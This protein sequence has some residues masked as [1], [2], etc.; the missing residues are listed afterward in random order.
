M[1]RPHHTGSVTPADLHRPAAGL[2]RFVEQVSVTRAT[3]APTPIER[4]PDG[5]AS[6]V[7]RARGSARCELFVVGPRTR[8]LFKRPAPADLAISIRFRPGQVGR[9]LGVPAGELTDLVLFVDQLWGDQGT[10]L[11]DALSAAAPPARLE[12]LQ[13]ALVARAGQS[14]EPPAAT[15]AR[16]AVGLLI[17]CGGAARIGA[18][19]AQLGITPRHLRRVFVA[20]VGVGPKE[21]ARM[22]R[23]QRAVR[24]DGA[25]SGWAATA[26]AL[27]Y[28]DQSHLIA[29]F[30]AL[31][32]MTPLEFA[33][34]DRA[35]EVEAAPG[36]MLATP[37]RLAAGRRG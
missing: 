23:L 8:A 35:P 30:R 6:L 26:A 25:P 12:L 37:Q 13:Q 3:A 29:E 20:T 28:T 19:A 34:R 27:G 33:R 31:V 2:A 36:P 1:Q 32:G 22:V 16:R 10:R 18:I 4:L 9:V 5:T 7:L 24:S 17:D 15:L 21:Y 14:H 11:V